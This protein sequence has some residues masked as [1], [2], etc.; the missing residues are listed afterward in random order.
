ME[1][2]LLR[3]DGTSQTITPKNGTDFKLEELRD[4]LDVRYIEVIYF[5]YDNNPDNLIMIGDDE[6]RL[7]DNPVVNPEATKLYR[8]SWRT[9]DVDIVGDV[10]LCHDDMLK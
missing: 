7:V 10:I 4:L 5:S 9:Y 2:K 3:V 1:A 8:K 6:G